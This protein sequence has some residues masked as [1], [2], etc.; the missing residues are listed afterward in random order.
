MTD[1]TCGFGGFCVRL[2]GHMGAHTR[3]PPKAVQRWDECKKLLAE[4]QWVLDYLDFPTPDFG[5]THDEQA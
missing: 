3:H 5:V 4:R 1:S 2:A